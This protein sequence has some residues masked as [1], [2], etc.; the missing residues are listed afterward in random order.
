MGS[1]ALLGYSNNQGGGNRKKKY[2]TWEI[3]SG[4]APPRPKATGSARVIRDKIYRSIHC[5]IE[6]CVNEH[7]IGDLKF[8]SPASAEEQK[9]KEI[10]Y[11]CIED[12][13]YLS[14]SLQWLEHIKKHLC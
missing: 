6:V 14:K 7:N 5:A 2:H 8:I 1:E 9:L 12:R 10:S 11:I 13:K 4:G 3:K